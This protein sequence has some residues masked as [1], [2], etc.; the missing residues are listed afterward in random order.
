MVIR[1]TQSDLHKQYES[2]IYNN[3]TEYGLTTSIS[4][5]DWKENIC[6][7]KNK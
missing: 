7:K 5:E 4:F 6:N 2:W 3:Y 1:D